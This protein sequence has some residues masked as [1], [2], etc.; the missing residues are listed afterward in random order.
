MRFLPNFLPSGRD[1]HPLPAFDSL[2]ASWGQTN[3]HSG[4]SPGQAMQ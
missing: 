2:R 3:T 4:L 1:H